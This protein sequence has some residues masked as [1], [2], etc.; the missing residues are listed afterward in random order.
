[1]VAL[2]EGGLKYG[3]KPLVDL[4]RGMALEAT[5]P[6]AIHLDHGSTYAS[7]LRAIRL[8]FTSVM[9]DQ[10]HEDEETNVRETR[11]VVEAAHAVGVTVEAE[12]G[13]LGG[14]EEH[15]VVA[16]E[17]A[18]LTKPDEA[19]RFM[20]ASGADYLAVAIG[21]SHGASKGKGRP[22]IDHERIAAIAARVPHPLVM[23]GASGVPT[24]L[25]ERFNAAGGS[26]AG[27]II[28]CGCQATGGLHTDWERVEDWPHIGYPI[29]ECRADGSFDLTKPAGTGGL[30]ARAA[31]A[32]QLLYEIGDPGAYLLPDVTCDFRSVVIEQVA[33]D[34][35]RVSG[36]RGRAP[37]DSYK[38]SATQLDGYRCAGSMVIIG[39]D[40]A[41]KA[42]RTGEAVIA[43][44]RHI[45][46][47]LGMPDYTSAHVA[48]LGAETLYGP[49]ARTSASR[50]V[51]VRISVTHP[52]KQALEI[53]AREIVP[54]GTSWS[55]GTT[56][57]SSGRPSA[58]PNIKP[59]SLLV[60]KS[61]V[62]VSVVIDGQRHP[63]VIAPGTGPA[64]SPAPLA[65]AAW[66]D[67]AEAQ[68]EVPLVRL[69]WARSGDKGDISNIGVIA[70][71]PAWMPLIWARLTPEVVKA[72]FAHLVQGEVQRF[73]L[74]GIHAL[75]ITMNAA[76]DG[77]G[78]AS[79]RMDPLGKGMG[80]MLLDLPVKVP[81]ALARQLG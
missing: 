29:I 4:V 68:V 25:V 52:M 76:L 49:H 5:V 21:T 6:V 42:R 24:A 45:L 13:R 58:S 27:H 43:R 79:S 57:P 51:M 10:S 39:I 31:V 38:V 7:C 81:A 63:S 62:S 54:S 55:P 35:V 72:Y 22:F 16:A 41:A 28:E 36:A 56:G 46:Q 44:T 2:S 59:L 26:L 70:R 66:D 34:R 1:L 73:Y 40:A 71:D 37:T 11:R 23:H 65:P 61:E 67:P 80:Q 8:G 69:A 50:E 12:I 78:P 20:E 17:D 9:I 47:S 74:P 3:G 18:T 64:E 15:V 75:N 48:L 53:F 60:K 19:E 32:E 30:I 14:I 33:S 77:G